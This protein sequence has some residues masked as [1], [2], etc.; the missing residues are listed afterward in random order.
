MHVC[1]Y[2]CSLDRASRNLNKPADYLRRFSDSKASPRRLSSQPSNF[3]EDGDGGCVGG[4]PTCLHFALVILLSCVVIGL[5]FILRLGLALPFSSQL[6]LFVCLFL[7]LCTYV[8]VCVDLPLPP[9]F[10]LSL[11]L[12]VCMSLFLS[13]GRSRTL[14]LWLY[15]SQLFLNSPSPFSLSLSL[16]LAVPRW[17]PSPEAALVPTNF[18]MFLMLQRIREIW[19]RGCR[20]QKER[21]RLSKERGR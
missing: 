17:P 6:C 13:L 9:S 2:E 4:H 10:L 15:L 5:F 1:V 8:C 16:S 14:C 21:G 3:S 20:E 7:S 18:L 11:S 19:R 12:S